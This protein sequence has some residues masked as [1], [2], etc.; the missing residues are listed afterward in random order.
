MHSNEKVYVKVFS[1]QRLPDNKL[2]ITVEYSFFNMN[3]SGKVGFT[4]SVMINSEKL[5]NDI[6]TVVANHLDQEYAPE[7]FKEKNI[8]LLS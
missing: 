6:K 2:A 3:R 7:E 4:P 5:R 8:I 1:H